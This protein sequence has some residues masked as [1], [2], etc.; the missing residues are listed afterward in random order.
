MRMCA[1]A[2]CVKARTLLYQ[3]S[4]QSYNAIHQQYHHRVTVSP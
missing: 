1:L 3:R 2:W 4:E